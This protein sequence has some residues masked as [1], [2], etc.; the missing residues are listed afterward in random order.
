[1]KTAV[2]FAMLLISSLSLGQFAVPASFWGMQFNKT[3]SPYPATG[4]PTVETFRFWDTGTSWDD[5]QTSAACTSSALTNCNFTKFDTWMNNYVNATGQ[6]KLDVIYTIGKTPNFISSNPTDTCSGSPAGSCVPPTDI[7]CTGT[8]A[9]NTGGTDA[10]FI[11]F[12]QALWTHIANNGW[13]TGRQ[14]YIEGWNEPNSGAVFWDQSWI[15]TTYCP[16]DSTAER[17]ILARLAADA[18]TTILALN[19]SV[20]FLTPPA[21]SALTAVESG[22]WWYKY[23]SGDGGMWGNG[24][25]CSGYT[26]PSPCGGGQ[27]ADVMSVHGYLDGATNETPDDICCGTG[28]LVSNTQATMS[29]FSQS[30]KPLFLTEG[31]WGSYCSSGCPTGFDP[32]AW[33]GRY[34]TL[35]LSQGKVARFAWYNYDTFAPLWCLSVGEGCTATGQL[36]TTGIATYQLQSV[37]NY[38]GG[39]FGSGGCMT[40]ATS[41]TGSGNIRACILT[42]GTTG[43]SAQVVWYDSYG[44]TCSHTPA[45]SG[46]IDYRDLAGN[47]TS[48]SH[49]PVTVG[50]SPILFEK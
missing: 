10:T 31:S 44:N 9:G 20:K 50:N 26:G 19:S 48:Y 32:V 46:W 49:G 2:L 17:R 28:T 38:D 35:M 11:N 42:E 6:P 37:W 16:G 36:S 4:G 24:S 5:I 33:T 22:G 23:L 15:D 30:S 40:T 41:C 29:T 45:G 21:S 47:V 12:L 1:M 39:T 25:T 27:F 7:T 13:D 3:T 14:W 34:Y 43:T 8:S 18:R